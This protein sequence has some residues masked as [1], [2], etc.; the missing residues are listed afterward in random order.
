M[1]I[2]QYRIYVVLSRSNSILF[3]SIPYILYYL[4]HTSSESRSHA[5]SSDTIISRNVSIQFTLYPSWLSS[6]HLYVSISI[7]ISITISIYIYIYLYL[8]LYLY[9]YIY[10]SILVSDEVYYLSVIMYIYSLSAVNRSLIYLWI[11]TIAETS[12]NPST[13]TSLQ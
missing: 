4:Y 8:Y 13:N 1:I 11:L 3:Y 6:K 12:I 2:L 10:I 5:K 9:I 7:S